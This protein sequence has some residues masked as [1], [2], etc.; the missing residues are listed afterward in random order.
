M[1]LEHLNRVIRP[2][3]QDEARLHVCIVANCNVAKVAQAHGKSVVFEETARAI[4]SFS[5][6]CM[7][8]AIVRPCL[9]MVEEAPT[10]N[11]TT[12]LVWKHEGLMTWAVGH[13]WNTQ[14]EL[15]RGVEA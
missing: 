12:Q 7:F 5:T 11:D 2:L 14:K 9:Y 6:V 4:W 3:K 1:L 15:L 8:D 13:R 10:H